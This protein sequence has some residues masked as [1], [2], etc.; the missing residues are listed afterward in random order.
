[1]MVEF[2]SSRTLRTARCFADAKEGLAL[3]TETETERAARADVWPRGSPGALECVTPGTCGGSR[4]GPSE[5]GLSAGGCSASSSVPA[6]GLDF[7]PQALRKRPCRAVVHQAICTF[8]C[9]SCW[10][11]GRGCG[12]GRPK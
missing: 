9:L 7:I 10:L 3:G 8:A 2:I 1:M 4:E 12:V 5:A 6:E 11:V